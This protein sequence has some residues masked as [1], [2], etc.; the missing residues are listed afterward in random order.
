MV[1]KVTVSDEV[2]AHRFP[3]SLSVISASGR[4]RNVENKGMGE[5]DRRDLLEKA[6]QNAVRHLQVRHTTEILIL[7]GKR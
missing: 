1:G 6:E 4:D 2:G 3:V 7:L 5:A